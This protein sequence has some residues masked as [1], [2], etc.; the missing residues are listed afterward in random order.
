MQLDQNA[1]LDFFGWVVAAYSF[2]QMIS[3]WL[4]GYWNQKTMSTKH[5][6]IC[7][8]TLAILGNILYGFLPLF[9]S[10]HKWY[11]IVARLLTGWGSG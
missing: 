9:S 11:M 2:G 5:P 1:D 10:N 4:F 6:A 8:L 3:S 7:G